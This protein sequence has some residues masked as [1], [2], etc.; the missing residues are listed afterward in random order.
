MIDQLTLAR[1][2]ELHPAVRE[3]VKN[4]YVNQIVPVL[5]SNVYC[6]FAYTLRTFAQQDELYAQ[7]RTK[8]FDSFG[9]RLGKVTNA[10]G[11]QSIHNYGLALDIVLIDGNVA[12]WNNVRDFDKDGKPDW[13][14]IVQI[15]KDNDWKWGGD[16]ISLID[17]PHFQK[18]FGYTW[19]DL[20]IKY[21]AG[22]FIKGTTYI[23]L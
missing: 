5:S 21:N 8:L 11:G 2:N 23:N 7:G 15:F 17:R 16:F 3:E 19:Q 20:L 13:M 1:I 14:E 6:R 9:N 12:S 4:I 22:D 10:K 18:T